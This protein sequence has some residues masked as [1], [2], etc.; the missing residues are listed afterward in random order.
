MKWYIDVITNNYFNF[1]GRAR[2]TEFWMYSLVHIIFLMITGMLHVSIFIAYAVLTI[3]PTIGVG[4]RRLHDSGK[5]GW[6]I[7]A[8]N[9]PI[10]FIY[11]YF[12]LL[13]SDDGGNLYGESPKDSY[14]DR[15]LRDE[16][17]DIVEYEDYNSSKSQSEAFNIRDL[18]PEKIFGNETYVQIIIVVLILLS[19]IF[20]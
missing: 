1:Y 11:Y 17:N 13:D 8:A 3:I 12:M 20:S 6:W 9:S 15:V 14:I 5:S 2:R 18:D 4:I 16:D 10:F 7:L 19:I